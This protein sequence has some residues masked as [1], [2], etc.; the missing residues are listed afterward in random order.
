[1]AEVESLS[2]LDGLSGDELREAPATSTLAKVA[3]DSASTAA[4]ST[5]CSRAAS[6]A[7]DFDE[8]EFGASVGSPVNLMASFDAVMSVSEDTCI[9]YDHVGWTYEQCLLSIL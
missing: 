1:M 5:A 9:S 6:E 7:G 3:G 2:D 8:P 4:P